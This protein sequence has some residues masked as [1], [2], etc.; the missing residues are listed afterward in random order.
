MF[1]LLF[2]RLHWFSER[3]CADISEQVCL[4][5]LMCSL[6]RVSLEMLYRGGSCNMQTPAYCKLSEFSVSSNTSR[7]V[8][9]TWCLTVAS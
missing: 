4:F 5:C 1:N 9:K 3:L 6:L 7:N 8:N 2:V